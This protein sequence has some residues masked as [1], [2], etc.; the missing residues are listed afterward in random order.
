MSRLDYNKWEKDIFSTINIEAGQKVQLT[1]T[2]WTES[3]YESKFTG[4]QE[5]QISCTVS[6]ID[7]DPVHNTVHNIRGSL[8]WKIIPVLKQAEVDGSVTVHISRVGQAKDTRYT[9]EVIKQ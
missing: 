4:K 3:E 2:D 1:Y 8:I 5:P 6:H 7:G 9:V